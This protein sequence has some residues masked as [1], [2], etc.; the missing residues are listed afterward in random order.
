MLLISFSIIITMG[1]YGWFNYTLA[2]VAGWVPSILMTIAVADS[3]HILISYF[4]SLRQGMERHDALRESL[5]INLNPVFITSLTTIIGVLCLNFSDSPPFRDLGN[6][7]ALGVFIAF[8]LSMTFLPALIVWLSIGSSQVKRNSSNF[9]DN[10]ANWVIKQQR[11]L[12]IVMSIFVIVVSSFISNNVLTEQW[13]HYFDDT[14]EIRNT[15]EGINEKLTGVHYLRYLI[16]S[17]E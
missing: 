4:H 12:L 3:V 8:I 14:F 1:I 7:V 6:M 5:R 11:K 2:P 10:F 15:I 13:H 16:D 17:G 9:M